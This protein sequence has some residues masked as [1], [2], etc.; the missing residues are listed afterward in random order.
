MHVCC[1]QS[2][3]E[4]MNATEVNRM[5]CISCRSS[6]VGIIH[7]QSGIDQD[8][9][10]LIPRTVTDSG[11]NCTESMLQGIYFAAIFKLMSNRLNELPSY[12]TM[13]SIGSPTS[14]TASGT[15]LSDLYMHNYYHTVFCKHSYRCSY[16][17]CRN[18]HS[19]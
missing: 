11:Q 16:S 15:P 19:R 13:I 10:T 2:G 7:S 5:I 12:N 18:S 6:C 3:G 8:N 1:T 9:I 14:T 4:D 17:S